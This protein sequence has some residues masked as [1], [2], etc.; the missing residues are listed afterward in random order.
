MISIGQ[1]QLSAFFHRIEFAELTLSQ[2][3]LANFASKGAHYLTR[4][5]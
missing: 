1:K 4:K 2:I 3:F 5:S